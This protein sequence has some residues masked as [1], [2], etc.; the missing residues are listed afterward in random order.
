LI[1]GGFSGMRNDWAHGSTAIHGKA[2]HFFNV[3]SWIVAAPENDPRSN[4]ETL[5]PKRHGAA[6]KFLITIEVDVVD[7][8]FASLNTIHY[9]LKVFVFDLQS[10]TD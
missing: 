4:T 9:L 8:R 6:R 5:C 3:N 10:I 2:F 7:A 1:V